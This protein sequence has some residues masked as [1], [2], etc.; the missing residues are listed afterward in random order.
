MEAK[1]QRRKVKLPRLSSVTLFVQSLVLLQIRESLGSCRVNQFV[2][3][4]VC[5]CM[6]TEWRTWQSICLGLWSLH[7]ILIFWCT[8]IC[9]WFEK[10]WGINCLT[11]VFSDFV[12]DCEARIRFWFCLYRPYSW[13]TMPGMHFHLSFLSILL[14]FIFIKFCFFDIFSLVSV[15]HLCAMKGSFCILQDEEGKIV[16]SED[17]HPLIHTDGTGFISK[18]LAMKC[19]KNIFKGNCLMHG[20]LEVYKLL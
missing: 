6:C 11:Q 7:H 15:V 10:V 9:P 16:Y 18:D 14:L 13:Y 8:Q 19:P 4:G 17:G 2:K 12:E 3:H 1:N 5:L 20:D